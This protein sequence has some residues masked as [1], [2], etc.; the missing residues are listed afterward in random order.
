MRKNLKVW[1]NTQIQDDT[2]IGDNV[3]I[4]HNCFISNGSRIGNNVK[5]GSNVDVWDRVIIEDD[6]FVAPSVVFTNDINPRACFPKKKFP[7]H[8]EWK[9]TIVKR[10]ATIGANATNLCG[11][12]IGEWSMVGAGAVVTASVPA[13]TTVV[14]NPARIIG[15]ICE[16]GNKIDNVY[17]DCKICGRK[18][19]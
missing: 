7:E 10:G 1:H 18:Y 19:K 11:L 16:C 9:T 12:T 4:G 2:E 13:N 14:G 5:I 3:S 8:G 6:V 15:C 17:A